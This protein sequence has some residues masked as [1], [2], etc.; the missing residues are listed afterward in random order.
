MT[1]EAWKLCKCNECCRGDGLPGY[2]CII[3][4]LDQAHRAGR[5]DLVE[6]ILADKNVHNINP[7]WLRGRIGQKGPGS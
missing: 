7:D 2:D 1:F 6:E 4:E 5:R 3:D